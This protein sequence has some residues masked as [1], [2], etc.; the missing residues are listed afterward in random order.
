MT[1]KTAKQLEDEI[2]RALHPTRDV[3]HLTTRPVYRRGY[4]MPTV[5]S[6][7]ATLSALRGRDV[8]FKRDTRALAI[9]AA[10]TYADR[11]NI[12]V[13]NRALMDARLQQEQG[14]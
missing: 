14:T 3:Y 4:Q 9:Q 10:L 8:K 11:R 7:I 12:E 13:E 6:Y 5:G 2:A 1:K